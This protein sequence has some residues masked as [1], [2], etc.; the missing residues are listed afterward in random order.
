MIEGIFEEIMNEDNKKTR[1]SIID[2]K[3][4]EIPIKG[5]MSFIKIDTRHGQI[6]IHATNDGG[7]QVS[8]PEGELDYLGMT[9]NKIYIGFVVEPPVVRTVGNP[10]NSTFKGTDPIWDE[11]RKM[12]HGD[13][14]KELGIKGID[15]VMD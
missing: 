2:A 9:N 5:T 10:I 14:D 12:K 6:R 13:E 11:R 1:V 7:I 4:E 15:W 8:S 3:G